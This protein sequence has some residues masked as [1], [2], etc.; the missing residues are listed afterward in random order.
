MRGDRTGGKLTKSAASDGVIKVPD[1]GAAAGQ[2][3]I[4]LVLQTLEQV[5]VPLEYLAQRAC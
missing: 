3:Q 5:G 2:V 4:I 1:A